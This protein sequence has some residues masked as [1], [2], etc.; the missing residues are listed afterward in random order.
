MIRLTERKSTID[1][2]VITILAYI[3]RLLGEQNQPQLAK[4]LGLSPKQ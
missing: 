3:S 4:L 1:H 2:I